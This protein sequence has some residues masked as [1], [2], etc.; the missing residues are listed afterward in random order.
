MTNAVF[1]PFVYSDP[2]DDEKKV[3][4]KKEETIESDVNLKDIDTK[5]YI[6]ITGDFKGEIQVFEN[7]GDAIQTKNK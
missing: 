4:E 3:E 5:K 7:F 6:V 2:D 1:A